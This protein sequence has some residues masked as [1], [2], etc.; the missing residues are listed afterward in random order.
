MAGLIFGIL[1]CSHSTPTTTSL[2]HVCSP[3]EAFSSRSV[4][5]TTAGV[6]KNNTKIKSKE[7]IKSARAHQL[8]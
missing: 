1:R 4:V 7:L 3:I 6:V 8:S 2:L 5:S